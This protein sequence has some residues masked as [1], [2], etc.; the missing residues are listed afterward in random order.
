MTIVHDNRWLAIIGVPL[1][2]VGLAIAIGP[3]FIEEARASGAWLIL[4]VGSLI[5]AGFIVFGLA[6]CFKYDG[7]SADRAAGEVVRHAG[8]Q[9]FR[10]SKTWPLSDFEEVLCHDL[11]MAASSAR[12]S[13]SI[14]YQVRLEGAD[15]SVVLASCFE[16]EL[17]PYEALRWAEFL[18][19]PV[20][21][22]IGPDL[23]SELRETL[24]GRDSRSG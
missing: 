1:A 2:V 24:A 19:L 13:S 11:R 4:A 10:R 15:A 5:G 17:V 18:D 3:W 9:P 23:A 22:A 12:G 14:Q 21:D 6:L 8:L 16:P 20:R 7:V